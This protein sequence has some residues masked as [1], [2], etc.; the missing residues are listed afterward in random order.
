MQRIAA[1][2]LLAI[3][4]GIIVLLIAM[5]YKMCADERIK[6]IEESVNRRSERLARQLVKEW[7]DGVQIQVMQRIIVFEDDLKKEEQHD[8]ENE[9]MAP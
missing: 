1:F 5:Y 6:E 4:C 9:N 8:T 2:V 3:C 7:L